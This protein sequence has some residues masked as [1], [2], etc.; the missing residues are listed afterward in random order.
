MIKALTQTTLDTSLY[1][2]G[3]HSHEQRKSGPDTDE[4]IVYSLAGD[5]EED[6]ADDEA[7]TKSAEITVRYYYRADMIETSAGRAR[8]RQIEDIIESSMYAEGFS[9]PFGHFDGGDV[10]DIGYL[11]TVFDF[12]YWRVV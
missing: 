1:P 7:L 12:E 6:H 9:L 5:G 2:L 10:D 3:I 8:V 11:V 4:Y